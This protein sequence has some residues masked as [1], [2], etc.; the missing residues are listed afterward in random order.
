MLIVAGSASSRL[1]ERV[2]NQL[3][4]ELTKPELKLFPDGELYVRIPADVKG[5]DVAIIQSTCYP[6]N[7]NYMELLLLLDAARDLG[8]EEITAIIPYFAYARQDNRFKEG[9]AV[10]LYTVAKL[11]ESVGTKKVYTVDM[12]AHRVGDIQEIFKVPARN[13]TAAPLLAKYLADNYQLEDPVIIGPDDESERWAKEAGEAL[14]ADWNHMVKE[15]L[16]PEEVHIKPRKQLEVE[17]RD[18]MVIDDIISTGETMVEAIKILK[19][20]GAR[21]IYAG[22]IHAVLAGNAREKVRKA[23]AEDVFATDTI[24]H[25]ISK[26]SVAPLIADAI[27]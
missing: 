14:G 22:C 13:L 8:A 20:H 26:V 10:S 18:A 17:G 11:I 23:G 16:G 2:A 3:K 12:H 9:E 27:H 6:P 24:E 15:R 7:Q 5:E 19:K 21:K 25:K 1:A 4:C